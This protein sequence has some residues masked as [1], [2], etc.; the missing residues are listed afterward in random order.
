[1]M[2]DDAQ[3]LAG[4]APGLLVVRGA[5][6]HNLKGVDLTLAAATPHCLYRRQRVRQVVAG[7]RHDLRRGPAPVRRVALGLRTS[8]SGADGEAGR[9]FAS[10]GS[11]RR[12]PFARRTPPGTRAPRSGPPPKSTTT[13]GCSGRVSAARSAGSVGK[14]S[15]ASLPIRWR[16]PSSVCPTA[17]ACCSRSNPLLEP[18][19]T[20]GVE[21]SESSSIDPRQGDLEEDDVPGPTAQPG[22]PVT[23]LLD[24]LRRHGFGRVLVGDH[25]LSVDEAQVQAATLRTLAAVTVIV[26]RVKVARDLRSRLTDSIET[27]F[28]RGGRCGARGRARRG[29]TADE[30]ASVQ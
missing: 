6:T 29:G 16:R 30:D 18:A 17:H 14:W 19:P 27:A 12:L 20:V 2:P 11:R 26:D 13:C 4:R 5:R 10:T 7:V 9:R 25:V 22:D 1:M 24:D 28:R 23:T 3:A 15:S 21:P 8:V